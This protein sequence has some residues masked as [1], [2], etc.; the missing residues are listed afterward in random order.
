MKNYKYLV[1][2]GCSFSRG[3]MMYPYVELGWSKEKNVLMQDL[4]RFSK[5]LS[6]KLGVEEINISGFGKSNDRIFRELFDWAGENEEKV[7]DSLFVVGLT[8]IFRKDLYSLHLDDYFISSEIYQDIGVIAELINASVKEVKRWRNFEL[9][10]MIDEVA[11]EKKLMR[12]CVLLDSY[13]RS[14]EGDIIFFNAMRRRDRVQKHEILST[15]IYEYKPLKQKWIRKS[16][17]KLLSHAAAP[18]VNHKLKFVEFDETGYKGWNWEEYIESYDSNYPT[19]PLGHP[20]EYD[21][22]LMAD[23]LYRFIK[24]I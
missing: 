22:F 19:N 24:D 11:L 8:N 1:V 9:K 20:G 17:G 3:G 18:M 10:Y 13:I 5:L 12:D 7:K 6:D 15:K 14:F 2:I 16:K 4:N 21:H 23:I